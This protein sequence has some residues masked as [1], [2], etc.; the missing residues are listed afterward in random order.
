MQTTTQN[1]TH[2]AIALHWVV[3]VLIFAGFGLGLFMTEMPF[4]PQKLKFYSYH[5]WIGITVFLFA[6]LR[7]LWRLTHPAP[8]LPAH[9]PAWQKK[10]AYVTHYLLYFLLFAIP[11][12]GWLFS[13]AK[14]LQTVY[15]EL[16][17]LPDLLNKEI[18]DIVLMASADP[19]NPFTAAEALRLLHKTLNFSMAALVVVHIAAAIKHYLFDRD[20]VMSQMIPA[21]KTQMPL[22]PLSAEAPMSESVHESDA[23]STIDIKF[24]ETRNRQ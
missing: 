21:L 24:P 23:A 12:A 3:A 11:I 17:P 7:I 16:V 9:M 15:L 4:S 13:S 20:N 10:A 22:Q 8:P 18:G 1:Y 2:T 14:G 5:K 6:A 19:D